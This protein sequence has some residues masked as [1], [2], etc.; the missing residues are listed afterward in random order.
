VRAAGV[1]T[2]LGHAQRGNAVTV[3]IEDGQFPILT[4][5]S[6]WPPTPCTVTT[7]VTRRSASGR[8][9]YNI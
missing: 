4:R 9:N 3:A 5:G 7:E 6:S 2:H 8:T 1:T